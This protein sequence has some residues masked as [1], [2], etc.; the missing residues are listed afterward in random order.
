MI[1]GLEIQGEVADSPNS[2]IEQQVSNG[3][4]IRR[5]L[6]VRALGQGSGPRDQ[7]SG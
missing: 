7:G 3:L 6:L 2:A 1:R 5:A 4:A